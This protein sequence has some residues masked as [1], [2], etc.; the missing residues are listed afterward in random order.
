MDPVEILLR[1]GADLEA[2]ELVL[3]EQ[4]LLKPPCWKDRSDYES[5]VL[6]TADGRDTKAKGVPRL[7]YGFNRLLGSVQQMCNLI[8]PEGSRQEPEDRTAHCCGRTSSK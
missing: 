6:E 2:K 1:S 4:R 5:C 3:G 8:S 7:V